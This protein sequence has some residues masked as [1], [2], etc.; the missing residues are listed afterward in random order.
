MNK[1]K[2]GMDHITNFCRDFD[3]GYRVKMGNEK[4]KPREFWLVDAT[5]NSGW[6][7]RTTE[8]KAVNVIHVR[9]VLDD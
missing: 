4:R 1:C 2:W 5:D 3:C 9:E 8:S 7:V 6:Q